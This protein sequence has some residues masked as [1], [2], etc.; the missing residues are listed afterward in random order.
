MM[1]Q[2]RPA[3]NA[4]ARPQSLA[5]L[6]QQLDKLEAENKALERDAE[7]FRKRQKLQR[8]L[9]DIRRKARGPAREAGAR[10]SA[11]WADAACF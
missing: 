4:G 3:V 6:K 2:S 1:L 10:R 7:R 8:E 9:E 11:S 5:A